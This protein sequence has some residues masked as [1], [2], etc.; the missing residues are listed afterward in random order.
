[1]EWQPI[2]RTSKPHNISELSGQPGVYEADVLVNVEPP[3]EW[4]MYFDDPKGHGPVEHQPRRA[5]SRTIQ[6]LF[7]SSESLK[8]T[9]GEMDNRIAQ[10]NRRYEENDLPRLVE[11]DRRRAEVLADYEKGMEQ[12]RSAADELGPPEE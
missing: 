1:M 9:V 2:K 5:G 6:V 8:T 10:A 7:S 4:W 11:E 12:M 3:V